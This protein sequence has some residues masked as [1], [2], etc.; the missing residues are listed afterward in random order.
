MAK[1]MMIELLSDPNVSGEGLKQFG[2]G[3]TEVIVDLRN[4]TV[5]DDLQELI[6]NEP[7]TP[8]VAIFYGAAHMKDMAKRL[9]DQL[10]YE[11]TG[12]VDWLT[13]IN[14]DVAHSALAP[15]DVRQMRMMIR[16]MIRQQFRPA[17]KKAG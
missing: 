3:F 8:T 10:G 11:P 9:K 15:A 17:A 6:K 16:Q 12:Q 14:V 5:I 7:A 2:E 13:A 4:Q 1:V